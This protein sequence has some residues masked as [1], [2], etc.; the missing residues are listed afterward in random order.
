MYMLGPID[1]TFLIY[2]VSATIQDKIKVVFINMFEEFMTINIIKMKQICLCIYILQLTD[3][4]VV[5]VL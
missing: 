3:S 5:F 4:N 2:C 1:N